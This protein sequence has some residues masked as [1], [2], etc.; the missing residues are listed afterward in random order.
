MRGCE[1]FG[2]AGIAPAGN[3]SKSEAPKLM[4]GRLY[5][6]PIWQPLWREDRNISQGPCSQGMRGQQPGNL[7]KQSEISWLAPGVI[8][9]FPWLS[10]ARKGV[11]KRSRE[12]ATAKCVSGG[13]PR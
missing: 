3:G 12:V 4:F 2:V 13:A 7:V 9:F 8:V 5:V 6:I 10:V 11:A 1:G